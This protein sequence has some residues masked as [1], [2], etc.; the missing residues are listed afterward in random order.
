[1]SLDEVKRAAMCS[2]NIVTHSQAQTG[3]TFLGAKKWLKDVF[4]TVLGNAGTTV[5]KNNLHTLCYRPGTDSQFT[6]LG[7]GIDVHS[8]SN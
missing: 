1:M 2:G 3:A 4:P 5:F 7:H 8:G 6:T